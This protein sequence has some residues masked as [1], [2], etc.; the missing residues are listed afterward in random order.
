MDSESELGW[1]FQSCGE[2]KGWFDGSFTSLRMTNK[3]VNG[4]TGR[5]SIGRIRVK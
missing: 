1:Y 4:I 5:I 2:S 3:G